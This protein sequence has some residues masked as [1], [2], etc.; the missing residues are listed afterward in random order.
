MKTSVK[1]LFL[2]FI[3]TFTLM[4][5]ALAGWLFFGFDFAGKRAAAFQNHDNFWSAAQWVQA[6]IYY[7]GVMVTAFGALT[8]AVL[9]KQIDILNKQIDIQQEQD[10][11]A[12]YRLL[13]APEMMV[14]KQIL[15]DDEIK[16]LLEGL[17]EVKSEPESELHRFREAV[18][19]RGMKIFAAVPTS[20]PALDY[21]ESLLNEYNYL[22]KLLIDKSLRKEFITAAGGNNFWRSYERLRPFIALR[23]MLNPDYA[24]EYELASEMFKSVGEKS[25]VA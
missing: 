6:L 4:V 23:R 20:R 18:N 11:R 3:F 1:S 16:R 17:Y 14:A 10:K 2:L 19:N 25:E 15:A 12:A 24:K 9:N 7:V 21:V 13:I 5:G 8:I 22:S